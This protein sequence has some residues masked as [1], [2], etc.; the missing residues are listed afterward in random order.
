MKSCSKLLV[1]VTKINYKE[2]NPVYL[3]RR[4]KLVAEEILT[5]NPLRMGESRILRSFGS[6]KGEAYKHSKA[7]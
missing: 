7:Q 5:L 4:I 3:F 6:K 1:T 2:Q